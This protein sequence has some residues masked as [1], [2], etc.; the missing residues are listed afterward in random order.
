MTFPQPSVFV[1]AQPDEDCHG[2]AVIGMAIAV[3]F[4]VVMVAVVALVTVLV[5]ALVR[6]W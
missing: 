6:M 1:P 2:G 5:T 3:G 4:S